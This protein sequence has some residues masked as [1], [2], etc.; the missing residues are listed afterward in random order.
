MFAVFVVVFL[1]AGGHR[2]PATSIEYS[3][4]T[5]QPLSSIDADPRQMRFEPV[6]FQPPDPDRIVLENG[7][8]VYL[9]ED[10]ELPLVMISATIQTGG[11]LDPPDKFGLAALTGS[12]LRTGGTQRIPAAELDEELE[13]LAIQLSATIGVESGVVTVDMLKKDLDRGLQIFV[14]VLR[15]PAFDPARVELAKLQAKESI[16][17]RQDQ[18]QSIAGREFAK[19][20]YGSHHPFARE[21]SMESVS[22]I[23]R[24]D[25]VGFHAASFHPNG[26][27]I[28]VTGDFEKEAMLTKLRTLFGDWAKGPVPPIVLPPVPVE[29]EREVRFVGKGTTQ[30]HLRAGHLSLKESDPD[31]PALVLLNDILGGGSFRSRLFQEVRTKQGLAYSVGSVLRPGSH[32]PGVWAI[33]TETKTASTQEMITRLVA[34][35]KRLREQPVTDGELKEAKEAFVNSFVFSFTSPASIVNRRIQLE[36]DGLPK[37]FVQ[38]LRDKVMQLTTEDLLRVARAQFHP[39]HLKILAVGPPE[40]ALVL[41]SFGEVK[42]IKL[43]SE[44]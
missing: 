26:I 30:T 27:I 5:Q 3:A 41:S 19:L 33:R 29:T 31:Y 24:D 32:E 17:R 43:E 36:Y 42:E 14:D 15:T 7:L 8:V 18:P 6:Q 9:L 16:R 35:L 44:N 22:R 13:R 39:D 37:D 40:T 21:S 10:H 2:S 34:N 20:L 23:S 25:V 28:G 12:A 1:L 11:W 38:Q 4:P